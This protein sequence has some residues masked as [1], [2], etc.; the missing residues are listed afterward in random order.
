[1]CL[2]YPSVKLWAHYGQDPLWIH[3][4]IPQVC[5]AH[6]WNFYAIVFWGFE[7][8]KFS[9]TNFLQNCYQQP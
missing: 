8:V 5:V 7:L 1:M 2:S 3:C 9:E 6:T 4:F